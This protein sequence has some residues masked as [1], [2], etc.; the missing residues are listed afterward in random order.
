MHATRFAA[1]DRVQA[2]MKEAL[3]GAFKDVYGQQLEKFTE[4]LAVYLD[5]DPPH[6][7]RPSTPPWNSGST[8]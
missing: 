5:S 3:D 6:L 4:F 8:S 1:L 2:N 7:T